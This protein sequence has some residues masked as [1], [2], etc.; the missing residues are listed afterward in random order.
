[1][2]RVAEV[3]NRCCGRDWRKAQE[4]DVQTRLLVDLQM[5]LPDGDEKRQL[6]N[7][8]MTLNGNLAAAA[9]A[10]DVEAEWGC[11]MRFQKGLQMRMRGSVTHRDW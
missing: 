10:G 4:P 3:Q 1:M 2:R 8:A 6:L 5:I 7:A 9:V 11:G